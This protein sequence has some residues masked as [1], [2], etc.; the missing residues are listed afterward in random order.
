MSE[1]YKWPFPVIFL[2]TLSRKIITGNTSFKPAKGTGIVFKIKK[3][4]CV[5]NQLINTILMV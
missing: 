4:G 5:L 2:V 3:L 1:N